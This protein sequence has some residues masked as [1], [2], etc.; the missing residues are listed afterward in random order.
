[1]LDFT[2][3]GM[4]WVRWLL[5]I[6]FFMYLMN[7]FKKGLKFPPGFTTQYA[8]KN[9]IEL[10]D[11]IWMKYKSPATSIYRTREIADFFS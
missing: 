10:A 11:K 3:L 5:H 4:I 2:K 7:S 8:K 1:M 9:G 6:D